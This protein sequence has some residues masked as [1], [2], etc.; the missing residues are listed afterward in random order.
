MNKFCRLFEWFPQV[1]EKGIT[2]FCLAVFKNERLIAAQ[3]NNKRVRL[4]NR[5]DLIVQVSHL[6][7]R[8]DD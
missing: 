4:A 3:N 1:D 5:N 7:K 8:S 2:L 6:S